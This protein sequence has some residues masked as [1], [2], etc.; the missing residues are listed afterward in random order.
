MS[1]SLNQNL[2]NI[3]GKHIAKCKA[4]IER[5]KNKTQNM[6]N[7]IAGE[8]SMHDSKSFS[9]SKHDVKFRETESLLPL[10]FYNKHVNR[11]KLDDMSSSLGKE[12]F[13]KK[14][15]FISEQEDPSNDT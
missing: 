3:A 12:Q 5:D 1:T 11:P 6:I 9:L 4:L 2:N 8:W 15:K 13:N 14:D 7:E 10:S